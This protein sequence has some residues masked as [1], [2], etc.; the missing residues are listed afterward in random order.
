MDI[1]SRASVTKSPDR[2]GMYLITFVDDKG[3]RRMDLDEEMPNQ[4]AAFSRASYLTGNGI[5]SA[6]WDGVGVWVWERKRSMAN[7][8]PPHHKIEVT[9][10][11]LFKID[12]EAR[13]IERERVLK[14]VEK[15]RDKI[16]Y[17]RRG[18]Y[19]LM[20]SSIDFPDRV[21]KILEE[22]VDEIKGD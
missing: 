14:I 17:E 6:P 20:R 13:R 18:V 4:R 22:M 15:T 2:D 5:V 19:S 7:I 9:A 11:E 16:A 12:N 8:K 1:I 21:D 10:E 3:E